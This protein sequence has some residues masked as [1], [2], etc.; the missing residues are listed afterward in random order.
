MKLIDEMLE[1]IGAKYI[2]YKH[3]KG[4]AITKV[5][6]KLGR[7]KKEFDIDWGEVELKLFDVK[8]K[9]RPDF[10]KMKDEMDKAEAEINEKY[11]PTMEA[12]KEDTRKATLS[13]IER[14]VKNAIK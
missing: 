1:K 11:K 3:I 8:E 9:Y 14:Q 13:E 12:Y 2:K 7:E 10:Q 5:S 4:T 6:Y